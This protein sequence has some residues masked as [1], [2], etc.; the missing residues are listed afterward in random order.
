[1]DNRGFL[2][3]YF[4]PLFK[5]VRRPWQI[6]PI[7]ILFGLGFDT[8]TEVALIA[9]SVGIGVSSSIPIW[10]I[11]VL[12]LMFTCGMVL[13]DTTDGVTMRMAYGWA[14]MNPIRKIYYNLTVT[15][16]SVLVALAIGSA[17]L[18]QVV[19]TELNLTGEFWGWL[20]NLDF[21]T[22]GYGIIGIFLVT[23]LVSLA[24]WK[25]RRFDQQYTP[26]LSPTE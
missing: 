15:V 24:V 1:L 16:I 11:L 4:R 6:F 21:E 8:A 17:E 14:F 19:A 26:K 3:R 20:N 22:I 7:G 10:M 25:I 2:N 18:T 5:I 23:W 13:I 9:I 12:P